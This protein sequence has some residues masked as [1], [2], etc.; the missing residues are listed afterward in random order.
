[1]KKHNFSMFKLLKKLIFWIFSF[2]L[3]VLAAFISLVYYAHEI[4]PQKLTVTNVDITIPGLPRQFAGLR[5]VQISDLHG[6]VFSDNKLTDQINKL[7]PDILVITGDVLDS[8]FTDITYIER[9]LGPLQ[10]EYGKFFVYGNNEYTSKLS[11][12]EMDAAYKKAGVTVLSNSNFRVGKKGGHLWLVGVEDPNTGRDRLDK[13]LTGTDIAP[14]ILLAHSPEII[15][16]ARDKKIDLVLVG[17]THGGQINIPG[18]AERP[19]LKDKV[20]LV[21]IKANLLLNRVLKFILNHQDSLAN[22]DLWNDQLALYSSRSAKLLSSELMFTN[23]VQPGFEQ[24]NAG[25][26]KVGDTAMYVNRG[27]GETRLPMRLFAPPEISVFTL[28]SR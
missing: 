7:N 4:E 14:R 6:K 20:N 9:V 17:H 11:R 27:L 19:D 23:N 2:T 28:I 8:R 1:M 15:N 26:F 10:A 13:A 16:K 12:K 18:L 21:L 22:L 3:I 24:Y 25:L 5:I